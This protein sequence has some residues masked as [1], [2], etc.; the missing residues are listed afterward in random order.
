MNPVHGGGT[1][2]CGGFGLFRAEY[3]YWYWYCHAVTPGE[4]VMITLAKLALTFTF[5]SCTAPCYTET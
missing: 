1:V 5:T 2:L 3:R 4:A